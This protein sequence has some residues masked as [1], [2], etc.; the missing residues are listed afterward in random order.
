MKLS[1]KF[2]AAIA[3]CTAVV[4]LATVALSATISGVGATFPFPIYAKWATA[5][6]AV[7]GNNLNY[8]SIG[9]GGG[10]KQIESRTVTF[11]A[12]DMPLPAAELNKFVLLQFPSVIGGVV[13]IVN[14]RGIASGQMVLDGPTLA[15]I[16]LGE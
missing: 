4:G 13:P 8:Q 15:S 14:V 5:Y 12:S 3:A 6:K 1:H 7:S 10:I 9:S 16:Y 2:I 11:G